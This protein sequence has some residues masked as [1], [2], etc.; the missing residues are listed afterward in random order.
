MQAQRLELAVQ[1]RALHANEV[2]RARDV[3]AE[4]LQLGLEI[5]GLYE[6]FEDNN[7][8]G[9]IDSPT[10]QFD[11]NKDYCDVSDCRLSVSKG[12][13]LPNL[14]NPRLVFER[15]FGAGVMGTKPAAPT[16]V[17]KAAAMRRV[18]RTS[19]S[20]SGLGRTQASMRSATGQVGSIWWSRR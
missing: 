1:G 15:I 4:A 6:P 10:Q 13:R 14:Y 3:A 9:L 18:A 12:S 8:D 5:N 19:L 7:K 17:D 20:L 16:P 2:G 11:D